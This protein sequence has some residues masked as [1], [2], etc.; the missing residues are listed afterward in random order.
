MDDSKQIF[1]GKT[2]KL[3]V[4]REG[5]TIERNFAQATQERTKRISHI[6]FDQIESLR[7]RYA[8]DKPGYIEIKAKA[9]SEAGT[10]FN[11]RQRIHFD[12][13]SAHRF[14][15]AQ[16][17]IARQIQAQ[18]EASPNSSAQPEIAPDSVPSPTPSYRPTPIQVPQAAA[19]QSLPT[20]PEAGAP[21]PP[22]PQLTPTDQPGD[23]SL[24]Y[25]GILG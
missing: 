19:P 25:R 3:I 4:G 16:K 21:L 23:P 12:A 18:L 8:A 17:H 10:M 2:G 24:P 15:R 9:G 1:T 14:R 11:R 5:V 7:H 6:S 13:A 20:P 22:P